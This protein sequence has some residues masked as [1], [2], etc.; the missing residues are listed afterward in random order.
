MTDELTCEECGETA[1]S[2]D[3][4]EPA[5]EVVSIDDDGSFD[6]YGKYDL[7]RCSGCRN[8]MGVGRS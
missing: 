1:E 6:L 3:D 4:L 7:F 8:P 5:G 2:A